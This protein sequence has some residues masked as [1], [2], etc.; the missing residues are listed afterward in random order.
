MA[1]ETP[2]KAYPLRTSIPILAPMPIHPTLPP[3]TSAGPFGLPPRAPITPPQG[4]SSLLSPLGELVTT[5][6]R[7]AY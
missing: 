6:D 5:T 7:P 1:D 2:L 3:P 4:P